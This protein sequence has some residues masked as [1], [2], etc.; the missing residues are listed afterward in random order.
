MRV[1]NTA[2]IDLLTDVADAIGDAASGRRGDV[3]QPL[4]R[5]GLRQ[6]QPLPATSGS[7]SAQGRVEQKKEVH[8]IHSCMHDE[9]N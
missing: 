6:G 4:L 9:R 5:R 1:A 3:T 8:D 2:P 7:T